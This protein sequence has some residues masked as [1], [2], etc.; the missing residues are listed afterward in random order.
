ML[1][2]FAAGPVAPLWTRIALGVVLLDLGVLGAY[3]FSAKPAQPALFVAWLMGPTTLGFFV[4]QAIPFFYPRFLL[5]ALPALCLLAAMGLMGLAQRG[6]PALVA[7]LLLLVGLMIPPLVGVYRLP[8]PAPDLRPLA[9]DLGPQLRPGD[10]LIFS[11][12]WQPGI[13]TAYLPDYLQPTYHASFFEADQFDPSLQAILD[14]H[15]RVWLLTYGVGAEDPINDV[16]LWLL[17]HSAT[18]GGAWYDSSQL[19]LFLSPELACNPG[20]PTVLATFDGGRITLR[21]APL[22]P[23]ATNLGEGLL[24]IALTWEAREVLSERYVVFVHLLADDNPVPVAQQDG[25]PANS[26]RPT[27]TWPVGQPIRDYHVLNTAGGTPAGVYRVVIG[28]YDSDT[29]ARVPVDGGGDS[30]TLG[31]V[32]GH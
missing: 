26:T 14:E 13:L 6:R 28:L 30:V 4:Q 7:G 2:E 8:N 19:T 25:Q 22:P 5:Y 17:E 12:S 10:G 3:R 9:A 29:L 27:Y 15:G 11:Y 31:V 16:G 32:S 20:P 24:L 23:G 18:P 1:G 21:Y